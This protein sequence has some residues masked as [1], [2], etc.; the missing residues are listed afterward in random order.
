LALVGLRDTYQADGRVVTQVLAPA[1][2]AP[3]LAANLS[4]VEALGSAY[5]DIQAPFG[6]FA[7]ATL[8]ASTRALQGDDATYAAIEASIVSLTTRRDNLA[9]LIRTAL[10]AAEFAS[11]PIDTAQAQSWIS[12]AGQL[13][14]DAAA[15]AAGM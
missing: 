1:A 3:A 5:K 6:P 2:R 7:L 8:T 4:T 9:A 10:D 15:L 14:S 12:Q 11:T 13:V